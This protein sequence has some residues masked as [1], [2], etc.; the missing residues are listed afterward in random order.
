MTR[1]RVLREP[2][3]HFVVLGALLFAAYGWLNDDAFTA[4]DE[5]VVD[6]NR[7][8]SLTA[9]FERLWSR[10]PTAAEREGLIQSFVREEILYREGL[11]RGLDRDD[12]IVRRRISQKMEFV[13]DEV[14]A[15]APTDTVLQAWLDAHATDYVLEP[16]VSVQQVYFNP[17]RRGATLDADLAR[18]K[19][20]LVSGKAGSA[21]LGDVTMLPSTQK[22]VRV[23]EVEDVFGREFAQTVAVSAVGDWHGPVRSSYGV[24]LVRVDM[25]VDARVPKLAEVR[26]AVERDWFREQSDKAGQAFYQVLRAR[27]AVRIDT[28]ANTGANTHVA[29]KTP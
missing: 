16:R 4:P 10:P 13:G 14:T 25:R 5:I 6:T 8:A 27:Y 29:V 15:S 24:H 17:A 11:A 28:D 1:R 3:L 19:S 21:R 12:P 18:A 9:Q 23:A 7:V 20:A 2:L 26:T 22:D